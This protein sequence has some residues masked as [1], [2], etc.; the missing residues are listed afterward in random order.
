[1]TSTL[2]DEECERVMDD[3][4]KAN[5]PFDDSMTPWINKRLPRQEDRE[6]FDNWNIHRIM[7][8]QVDT[9][10]PLPRDYW[11]KIISTNFCNRNSVSS[12]ATLL[13]GNKNPYIALGSHQGILYRLWPNPSVL[14]I[15]DDQVDSNEKR[16]LCGGGG[17]ILGANMLLSQSRRRR[18][19]PSDESTG[20]DDSTQ[21]NDDTGFVFVQLGQV[22][23]TTPAVRNAILS[24]SSQNNPADVPW[25]DTGYALVAEITASNTVGPVWILYNMNPIYPEVGD[26][27]PIDAEST[28][29]GYLENDSIRRAGVKIANHVTELGENYTWNLQKPLE[30]YK[31]VYAIYGEQALVGERIYR[32]KY[33]LQDDNKQPQYEGKGKAA[34]YG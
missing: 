10:T 7:S 2:S 12:L 34:I 32:A 11:T 15:P 31:L 9:T 16:Q 13:D 28:E 33:S 14:E 1:M 29:W 27:T 17:F 26:R 5:I 18:Q 3:L 6:R 4:I 22:E 8:R 21:G 20:S 23:S 19:E 30:K 24:R 25:D